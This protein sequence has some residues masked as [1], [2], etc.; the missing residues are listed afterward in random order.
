LLALLLGC[1]V[2]CLRGLLGIPAGCPVAEVLGGQGAG[3][4]SALTLA[5]I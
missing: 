1:R 2:G 3:Q 4:V 5:A